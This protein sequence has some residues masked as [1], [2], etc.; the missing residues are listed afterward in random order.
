MVPVPPRLAEAGGVPARRVKAMAVEKRVG[1]REN[2]GGADE[3]SDG[4]RRAR[5]DRV[6]RALVRAAASDEREAEAV[7]ASPFLYARVRARIDAE[8]ARREEGEGRLAMLLV[9]WRAVPALALVAVLA[10][11]LFLSAGAASGRNA[12]GFVDEALL[13]EREGGFEQVVFA[14]GRA[15]S[16]DE[17][18]STILGDE[19]EPAR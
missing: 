5:L 19:K 8:R 14:D 4:A 15:P 18:L 13:G 2:N 6:G 9:A 10:L 11:A 16:S 17:V 12:R 1:A 3:K 7:A